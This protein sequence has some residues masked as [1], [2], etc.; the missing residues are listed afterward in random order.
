[1]TMKGLDRRWLCVACAAAV[2]AV[3]TAA[4]AAPAAAPA[5]AAAKPAAAAPKAAAP[6]K[7][8]APWAG[9][10]LREA[11]RTLDAT[12]RSWLGKG[13][14]RG[15]GYVYGM[16]LAPLLLY[17]AERKDADL[18]HRLS[19]TAARLVVTGTPATEGFVLWRYRDGAP[20]EVSGATEAVWLA[21]ALAAGSRAFN[22]P[23]DRALAG[24]VLAGYGRH[25]ADHAGTWYVRKYYAFG[26]QSYASLSVLPAYQ[27]DFIKDA[28]GY[29][30]A[31][32]GVAQ[33]SYA[34]LQRA[35]SPSKLLVPVI[36]PEVGSD[37][38]GMDAQRYAPNN[39]VSL[40]DSCLATEGA[41]RGM[42]D[43]ARSMLSFAAEPAR[44]DDTGRL[45]GY[46]H[47][48]TGKPAGKAPLGS[49]GYACLARVAVG[50]NDRKSAASFE[51][52]L[53]GDMLALAAMPRDEGAPLYSAGPLL[54]AAVA[55]GAFTGP[56]APAGTTAAAHSR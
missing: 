20:P 43:L 7:P 26:T 8:T 33:R 18:Y 27:P 14:A 15:D 39:L 19:T 22:R 41:L 32:K 40:E 5:P 16:D 29:A 48:A 3:S 42:P 9:P 2:T 45:Y 17:A 24:K 35:V 4:L 54:R 52:A 21:R 47:R 36:Q 46:Y 37:F 10:E 34:T 50:L 55:L 31:V 30:P 28:E 13:P 56:T 1:M 12:V 23:A 53:T 51:M 25:A 6:A 49:A 11:A 44:K 38:P